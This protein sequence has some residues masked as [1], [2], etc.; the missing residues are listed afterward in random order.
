MD[1]LL[2]S[3]SSAQKA[4]ASTEGEFEAYV[5]QT[6]KSIELASLNSFL[7]QRFFPSLA[8]LRIFKDEEKA[9]P[10]LQRPLFL[11][12]FSVE[13]SKSP[14]TLE[15]FEEIISN[16][17]VFF[18]K[19]PKVFALENIHSI[20]VPES[21]AEDLFANLLALITSNENLFVFYL[22]RLTLFLLFQDMVKKR[23]RFFSFGERFIWNEQ[24]IFKEFMGV[25][26]KRA[27][28]ILRDLFLL[29]VRA[30]APP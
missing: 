9:R 11:D 20:E 8:E 4:Y 27:I 3:F 24:Y 12:Q 29:R 13:N 22:E 17:K 14:K 2:K 19:L 28:K 26:M 23:K 15:S 5:S 25:I 16:M 30:L 1:E 21:L 6:Q 7:L 10:S 18:K